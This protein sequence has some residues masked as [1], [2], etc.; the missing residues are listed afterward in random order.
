MNKAARKII[1]NLMPTLLCLVLVLMT[2]M[3]FS[4]IPFYAVP[5][6]LVLVVIFY[7]AVFHPSVLNC[8]CVFLI[9]VFA[10]ML[11]DGP[12]GLQAFSYVLLFFLANVNRRLLLSLTFGG[13][14]AAFGAILFV[15]Y[16]TWYLLFCLATLSWLN[17]DALVFQYMT[18]LICYPLASFACGWFNVKVFGETR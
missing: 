6:P 17:A 15:V 12:F 11:T 18:L 13:V 4:I 8:I 5:L 16:F 10:D 3:P 1:I 7:F 9:G 14:W 2:L